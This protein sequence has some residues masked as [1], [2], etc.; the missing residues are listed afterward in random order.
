VGKGDPSAAGIARAVRVGKNFDLARVDSDGTP[1][2]TGG[3][4]HA[5]RAMERDAEELTDLQERLFA[6]KQQS[7]LLIVQGM[8]TAGKGGIMRHVVG[9]V[10]P[11]GVRIKAFKAPTKEELAHP[12]L[13]RIKN[14]LP[15]PGYI[16]VFD[17]SQ[18]EDVLVVRVHDL[19]PRN[20]WSRRYEQINKFEKKVVESGTRIIKVMLHVSKD[21]QK[22]RLTERLTR[23]DK[24]WKFNPR[25]IDE[26]GHWDE[27]MD[28][29]QAVLDRTNT[30]YAP[31]HVVPA[32]NKWF[33]RLAVNQLLL[34]ELRSLKLKWPPADFDVKEERK[35]LE[36]T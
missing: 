17:R 25:D 15:Q 7:V 36:A 34:K 32:D 4:K 6:A 27:Y 18:Y 24:Y 29:Y 23:K 5:A 35:R 22:A 26:R 12:F 33:A 16:G 30:S 3:K 21:E 9:E 8:D 14:A 1:G 10:D 31:W 13:W 20:V 11:Q 19:V 2:W 28:A